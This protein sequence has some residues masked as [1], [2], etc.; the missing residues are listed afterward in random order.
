M[1][2]KL[3]S[4]ELTIRKFISQRLTDSRNRA[5]K[6]GW[7]YN[8]DADFL[9]S[10]LRQSGGRCP[11]TGQKFILEAKNP[12]NFSVDRYDNSKGYTKDNVW[13]ISAWANKAKNNLSIDEFYNFC[14]NVTEA[15]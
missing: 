11:A 7:D 10:L 13:L 8:L 9:Q 14:A 5:K 4:N 15:K 6:K 2:K 1:S 3:L 12:M